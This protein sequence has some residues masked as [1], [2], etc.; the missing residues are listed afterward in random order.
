M[1]NNILFILS[2]IKNSNYAILILGLI[3]AFSYE[4]FF[5]ICSFIGYRY[6]GGSQSFS[7]K[8]YIIGIFSL[9]IIFYSISTFNQEKKIILRDLRIIIIPIFFIFS[10]LSYFI[11]NINVNNSANLFTLYFILFN[12][13]ALLMGLLVGRDNLFSEFSKIIDP[14]II[15]STLSFMF[16]YVV[17][18]F[19]GRE[20]IDFGGVNYQTASYIA[21]LIFGLNLNF[22]IFDNF[23]NR[24]SIFRNNKYKYLCIFMLSIQIMAVIIPGGRGGF[25][26]M[27]IYAFIIYMLS[28]KYL[29]KK[30]INIRSIALSISVIIFTMLILG[31]ANSSDNQGF[32]RSTEYL[33]FN[34]LDT[35]PKSV[36]DT[37]PKSV[38]DTNPKSPSDT[39]LTAEATNDLILSPERAVD[40]PLHPWLRLT[41]INWGGTS[42][43]GGIYS[44][45]IRLILNKPF[46]GYGLFGFWDVSGYPHNIL[47]EILLQGGLFYFSIASVFFLYIGIKILRLVKADE[48]SFI[49]VLLT[50]FPF[51]Q[52][53]FSGTYLNSASLWFCFGL[54]YA[55][56]IR[57]PG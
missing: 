52:L 32:H 22:I 47:L 19:F 18:Y 1:F 7:Y 25:L 11:F 34:G 51:I 30:L 21:A 20:F 48:N 27:A 55:L 41:G 53:Q 28:I 6:P 17:G 42:N 31:V 35:N 3:S 50:L 45:V 15:I 36:S 26:L 2:K 43:R 37:T 12:I 57:R 56:P 54:I 4:L 10:Y 39:S 46:F 29:F 24:F 38:S 49:L 9:S 33:R 5:V 14:L 13:P 23:D 16:S 8:L 44:N 40:A